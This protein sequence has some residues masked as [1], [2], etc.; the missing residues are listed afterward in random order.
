MAAAELTPFYYDLHI[1]TCLSPCGEN[2]MTPATVAGLSALAG[3]DIIAICDHN[4]AGNVQAVQQAAAALAPGLLVIP[5]IELTCAEELHMVCLFPTAE[6]AEAAGEEIYA[7]LPPIS[8][9]EEIFGA[10][11]LMDAEDNELGRLEKLLSNATFL[12]IDDAPALAARYGGFCYPAHI[13]RDSMSVLAALGE[14]PDHLGFHTV[15]VA[16]PE[17]FFIG[18]RNASYPEKY[19]ILTCSDAHRTEALLPDASHAIH[20][21]ECTFEALKAVLT[22]PKGSAFTPGYF[23]PHTKIQPNSSPYGGCSSFLP[24]ARRSLRPQTRWLRHRSE[25]RSLARPKGGRPAAA[26]PP[27]PP[28]QNQKGSPHHR[29][30]PPAFSV[31]FL[32]QRLTQHPQERERRQYQPRRHGKNAFQ[33][34]HVP[35]TCRKVHPGRGV[36]LQPPARYQVAQRHIHRHKSYNR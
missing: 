7:A 21:P 6:A 31:L 18:G 33:Q 34:C 4:T 36:Q 25:L 15:E 11:L 29:D 5:G 30:C 35:Q 3:L 17:K 2:D 28:L 26:P 19:H 9:R 24:P 14:V 32:R 13:D 27:A 1:H 16:D 20:L 12:S 10:Q 23:G 8:N 22:T